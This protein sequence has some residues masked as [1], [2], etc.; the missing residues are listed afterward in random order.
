MEDWENKLLEDT[1]TERTEKIN[2]IEI[3]YRR[4]GWY[5]IE[6]IKGKHFRVDKEEG[7]VVDS[8]EYSKEVLSKGII[9]GPWNPSVKPAVILKFKQDVVDK[10]L[11]KITGSKTPVP[12]NMQDIKKKSE[13]PL[14]K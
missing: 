11:E 3:T 9:S 5:E 7:L 13:K 14:K 12:E 2:G 8:A 1:S 6:K 10:L 4:L